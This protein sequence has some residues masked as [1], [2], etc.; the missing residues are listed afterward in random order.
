M[1]GV[2]G[3]ADAPIVASYGGVRLRWHARELRGDR[4]LAE[5]ARATGINRDELSRIERGETVQIRF[6]TLAKLVEGYGCAVSDLIEIAATE[7][8]AAAAPWRGP[9]AALRAGRVRA[10]VPGRPDPDTAL[11][12]F[13]VNDV[14][15]DVSGR[16]AERA[17]ADE[18]HRGAFRPTRSC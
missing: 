12:E 5:A 14:G 2:A 18:V 8:D 13:E 6:E 9:L 1:L 7:P 10:G 17:S 4:T 11:D 3:S 16:F 15:Q